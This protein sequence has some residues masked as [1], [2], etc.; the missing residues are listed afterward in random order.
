MP[1]NVPLPCTTKKIIPVLDGVFGVHF[2]VG[3]VEGLDDGRTDDGVLNLAIGGAQLWSAVDGWL[4][5]RDCN[6]VNAERLR[7]HLLSV[8]EDTT[9]VVERTR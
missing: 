9:Q 7:R 4:R 5:V 2:V 8:N 3:G 6:R 1:D